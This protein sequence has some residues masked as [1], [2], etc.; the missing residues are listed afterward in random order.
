MKFRG[1]RLSDSE[2]IDTFK[3]Q[4]AYTCT[5]Q[6]K[7]L[8]IQED[9]HVLIEIEKSYTYSVKVTSDLANIYIFCN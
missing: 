9:M 6:V 7:Y 3:V 1:F 4:R 2:L 8:Q 5:V